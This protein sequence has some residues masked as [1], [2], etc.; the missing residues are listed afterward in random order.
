MKRDV[1]CLAKTCANISADNAEG[2]KQAG[3][4]TTKTAVS[5][6]HLGAE[7]LRNHCIFLLSP[8]VCQH[9][10]YFHN[11]VHNRRKTDSCDMILQTC[12]VSGLFPGWM[13]EWVEDVH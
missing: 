7:L 13:N 3:R 9:L 1:F 8:I 4:A 11:S 10:T 6:C 12:I 5:K 2:N